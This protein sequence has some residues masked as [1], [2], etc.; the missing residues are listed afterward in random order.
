MWTGAPAA[1]SAENEGDSKARRSVR[2]LRVSAPP[3]A[4]ADDDHEAVSSNVM[5][6]PFSGL[7]SWR[8]T[9][10][11]L[12]DLP[13][14]MNVL[15]QCADQLLLRVIQL[16]LGAICPLDGDCRRTVVARE[17]RVLG[18]ADLLA[19]DPDV[20]GGVDAVEAL[21]DVAP[22]PV[23]GNG[24][25]RAIRRH[26]VTETPRRRRARPR[27]RPRACRSRIFVEPHDLRAERRPDGQR[28]RQGARESHLDFCLSYVLETSSHS[29][30]SQPWKTR[31]MRW[32]ST[33]PPCSRKFQ[34]RTRSWSV[35]YRSICAAAASR[36]FA[37]AFR[38]DLLA[39]LQRYARLQTCA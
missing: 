6:R 9:P 26:G 21:D 27:P 13:L 36:I 29:A 14:T 18:V 24:E 35:A 8:L 30:T 2:L 1:L 19:V 39:M 16:R 34:S 38:L 37:S 10:L 22:L 17:L 28:A 7:A 5:A 3:V 20:A 15:R 25:R 12:T 32:R 33:G 11:N 31:T 4:L 23:L